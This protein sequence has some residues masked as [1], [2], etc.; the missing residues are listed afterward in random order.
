MMFAEQYPTEMKVRAA[1]KAYGSW[2]AICARGMLPRGV[3]EALVKPD[4]VG[5]RPPPPQS[6]AS[7]FMRQ[8]YAVLG[9][10]RGS[11]R[12]HTIGYEVLWLTALQRGIEQ[13]IYALERKHRNQAPAEGAPGLL[14]FAAPTAP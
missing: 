7:P 4:A 5:G 14:K 3:F 2:S 6:S 12:P 9:R 13:E 8:Y 11:L 1:L 10:I